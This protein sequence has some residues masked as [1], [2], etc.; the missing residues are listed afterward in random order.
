MFI[1]TGK[2]LQNQNQHFKL[3]TRE[4]VPVVDPVSDV[5]QK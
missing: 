5:V 1:Q 4:P 2:N 3:S